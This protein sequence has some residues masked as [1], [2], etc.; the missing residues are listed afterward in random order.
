M[1]IFFQEESQNWIQVTSS[2]SQKLA[3]SGVERDIKSGLPNIEIQ[4]LKE[5]GLLSLVIPQKYGGSGATW[6]EALKIVQEL[7][8]A[9]GSIGQLYGNHLNLTAL[10]HVLG[11][12]QQKERYDRETAKKNLFWANAINKRDKKLKIT[13]DGSITLLMV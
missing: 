4:R 3:S 12:P 10:A 9:D 7:S 13:P 5:I 2:L 1:Q 8:Q 6:V 11:T